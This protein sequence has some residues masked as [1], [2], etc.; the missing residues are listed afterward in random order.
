MATN[1]HRARRQ[2]RGAP[3]VHPY[4]ACA[5]PAYA[6]VPGTDASRY[7]NGGWW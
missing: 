3:H 1:V 2:R 4:R 5:D 6:D 7:D